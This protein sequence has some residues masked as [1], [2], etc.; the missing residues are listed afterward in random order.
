MTKKIISIL[1]LLCTISS[2]LFGCAKKESPYIITFNNTQTNQTTKDFLDKDGNVILNQDELTKVFAFYAQYQRDYV[3]NY[4][5]AYSSYYGTTFDEYLKQQ[6]SNGTTYAES[7]IEDVKTIFMEY[8]VTKKQIKEIGLS[9]SEEEQ[10]IVDET[11]SQT[12]SSFGEEK[13]SSVCEKLGISEDDFKEYTIS[14]A[15]MTSLLADY[16]YGENGQ[17]AVTNETLLNNFNE[18]YRRFKYIILSKV[19]ESGNALS[20]DD[21]AAKKQKAE[22]VLQQVNAGANFEDLV[23]TASEAY[24]DPATATTDDDKNTINEMNEIMLNDGL[25]ADANGIYDKTSYNNYGSIVDSN[26]ITQV[27]QMNVD[28]CALIELDSAFWIVKLYD[29]NEKTEYFDNKRSD[30]FDSIV[31]PLMTEKIN[32]WTSEL[33]YTY[34]DETISQ[35]NPTNLSPIL[36]EETNSSSNSSSTK[37]TNEDKTGISAETII[38]ICLAGVLVIVAALVILM[39]ILGNKKKKALLATTLNTESNEVESADNEQPI[40][41][42][43]QEQPE[44]TAVEIE[45]HKDEDYQ[46]VFG[47]ED[48]ENK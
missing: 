23:V 1:V 6:N 37:S 46:S 29:L 5:T 31:N 35:Y 25:I 3:D 9:F 38:I 44:N 12:K 20:T 17:E 10:K 33:N 48:S 4:I 43:T 7:I 24:T 30:I 15:Y 32:N 42:D 41:N 22:S 40:A 8:L 16:Y 13:F 28:E 34:N 19:D 36:I 11:F 27:F 45:N 21:L 2:V 14:H 26:V 18:N 39:I 47:N